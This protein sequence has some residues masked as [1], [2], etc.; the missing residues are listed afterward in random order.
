MD[1]KFRSENLKRKHHL[2]DLDVGGRIILK[3]ILKEIEC[4]DL[5]WIQLDQDKD[6]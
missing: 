1:A 4:E 2:E 5:D 3:L 6:Q